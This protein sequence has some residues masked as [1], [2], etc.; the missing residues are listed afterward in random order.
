MGYTPAKNLDAYS[1]DSFGRSRISQLMSQ[2]NLVQIRD[3][4][5]LF[6]DEVVNGT[7]TSV[8][9]T[10]EASTLMTTSSSG[11]YV[12]RQTK[13]R[14]HYLAG[15]SQIIL[16]TFAKFHQET[17]IEKKSG[18]YSS[19]TVAPYTANLDGIFFSSDSDGIAVNIYKSGTVTDKTLQADWI[20]DKLD[21]SGPSGVTIDWS[22][23]QIF[24]FDFQYLGVG[25]VRWFLAHNDTL[26]HF[27]STYNANVID[28]V[29][30]SSPNQ[31][32][33][34]EIRQTGVGSGQLR[35]ICAAVSSEG[36]LDDIGFIRSENSGMT[37]V[38]MNSTGV[39]Y[40][41]MGIRL[42][43]THADAQIVL[44]SLSFLEETNDNYLWQIKLN[45]TIAGTFTYSDVSNSSV[46]I[47]KGTT[48]NVITPTTG[49]LLPSGYGFKNTSKELDLKD[50]IRLGMKIDGT[51]DELVITGTPKSPNADIS[52]ALNWR[53]KI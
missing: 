1:I 7:A 16:R 49:I 34:C 23:S 46:Q 9:Q 8:H 44:N 37:H 45:P 21:G 41:I 53:E 11:D 30:M 25:H 19:S 32:I 18:Y 35:E 6:I 36:T 2:F 17:N 31:P 29:Y 38:N 43:S 40:A 48:A 26:I 52:L 4:N 20:F 22:K 42:K 14:F 12:I 51:M 5:P 28:S 33:R 3:K 39:E 27:H 24:I 50:S 10:N 47:A 15:K 13:Q